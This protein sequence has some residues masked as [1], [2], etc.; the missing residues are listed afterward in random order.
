MDANQRVAEWLAMAEAFNRGDLGPLAALLADDCVFESS[1]GNVGS[2][3]D[4]IMRSIQEGRDAGWLRHEPLAP[5][6]AGDFVVGSFENHY[7]DGSSVI[8]AGILRYGAD[9]KVVEIRSMEPLDF[10]ERM[11]AG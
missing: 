11:S 7:A 2:S 6:G 10:V 8:G 1:T 3:K 5:S 9:D 4:E